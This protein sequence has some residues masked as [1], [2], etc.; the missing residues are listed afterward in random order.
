RGHHRRGHNRN[1]PPYA[2]GSMHVTRLL[3][4]GAR[5][6]EQRALIDA[7]VLAPIVWH[8]HRDGLLT[9]ASA[10]IASL[11]EQMI[12]AGVTAAFASGGKRD[13]A[14][15]DAERIATDVAWLGELRLLILADF[16]DDDADG[17]AVRIGDAA[18][19]HR[20]E[21]SIWR[22]DLRH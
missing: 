5:R 15:A 20:H 19:R 8:A 6:V 18:D 21:A 14:R 11:H 12:D 9:A 4:A 22:P 1:R 7:A 10:T 2:A 17:V 3:F 13:L 16:G